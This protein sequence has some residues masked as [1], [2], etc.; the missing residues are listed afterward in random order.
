MGR[1]TNIEV[2]DGQAILGPPVVFDRENIDRY[3]F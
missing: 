1:L 2:K 3:Q